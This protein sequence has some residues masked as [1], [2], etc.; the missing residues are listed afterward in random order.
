MHVFWVRTF[1]SC[2]LVV[3]LSYHLILSFF[4][5]ESLWRASY[6]SNVPA[7]M[8]IFFV[9]FLGRKIKLSYMPPLKDQQVTEKT[10]PG[11]K[12]TFDLNMFGAT[13]GNSLVYHQS[14]D[15]LRLCQNRPCLFFSASKASE[16]TVQQPPK[17]FRKWF[18]IHSINRMLWTI[19]LK[20]I[21]TPQL[22]LLDKIENSMCGHGGNV[23]KPKD[24]L[25]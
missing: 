8:T 2:L 15:Q 5:W 25:P 14:T 21:T 11:K 12:N 19:L 24:F 7:N 16:S 22:K 13:L 1:A 18:G 17:C 20:K 23:W 9:T 3:C 10:S 4:A 6:Y